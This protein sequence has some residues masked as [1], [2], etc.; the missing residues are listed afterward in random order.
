[1]RYE[2]LN[3]MTDAAT[4]LLEAAERLFAKKGITSVSIREINREAGN[5][6][7]TALQYH[8][9]SLEQLV[10]AI[11]DYRV[12]PLNQAREEYLST[13]SAPEGDKEKLRHLVSAIIVPFAYQLLQPTQENCYISLLAQIFSTDDGIDIFF[14]N[15]ERVTAI[16]AV[17]AEIA[18]L[19]SHLPDAVLLERMQLLGATT[20]NTVARWEREQRTGRRIFNEETLG[21]L[22]DDL[23]TFLVEG[24]M[25][26][27]HRR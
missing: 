4:Q 16:N 6:N 5:K 7:H 23:I 8:F 27:P 11:L 2:N 9:G 12:L 10:Q 19:L 13:H 21:Q 1:M 18:K 3:E 24:L 26:E 25:A 17:N 14:Q 20:I 15:P 22:A